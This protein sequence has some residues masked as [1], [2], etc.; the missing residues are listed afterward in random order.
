MILKKLISKLN[1]LKEHICYKE[2][3]K[4]FTKK[5]TGKKC[6]LC[7][8]EIETLEHFLLYCAALHE[9][10]KTVFPVFRDTIVQAIGGE[11]WNQI[12]GGNN[13]LLIQ[14]I[15]DNTAVIDILGINSEQSILI[16]KESRNLCYKL[17]VKRA[18]LRNHRN[19]Q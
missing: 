15:I 18:L 13:N 10:R 5:L 6:D 17:H 16:E 11:R 12:Y 14:T 7:Q 2:T 4:N 19:K 1:F 8:I 3:Y 9:V